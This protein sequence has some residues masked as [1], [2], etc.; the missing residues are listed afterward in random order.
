MEQLIE[1]LETAQKHFE[2]GRNAEAITELDF[3]KNEC[4]GMVRRIK[5]IQ[6]NAE[7]AL[8]TSAQIE[9]KKEEAKKEAEKEE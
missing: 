3:V 1:A 6:R 8:L 7:N 4:A 5:G 2:S 9:A